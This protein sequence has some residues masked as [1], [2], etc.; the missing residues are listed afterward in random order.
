MR[1]YI[2]DYIQDTHVELKN[3]TLKEK[4]EACISNGGRRDFEEGS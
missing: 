1:D 3:S 4:S 2:Q